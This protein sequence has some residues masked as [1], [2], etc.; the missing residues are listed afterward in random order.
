MADRRLNCRSWVF[1]IGLVL[2]LVMS[3]QTVTP[4]CA[5]EV[6]KADIRKPI[7]PDPKATAAVANATAALVKEATAGL[8]DKTGKLREKSDYFVEK[9]SADVTPDAILAALEHSLSSDRRMDAYVKWQLLSGVSGRFPEE[10]VPRAI[11][12]YRRAPEL[13][14]HPGLDRTQLTRNLNRMGMMKREKMGEINL[15]LS[16]SADQVT[17]ENQYVLHYRKELYAHLPVSGDSLLAGLDD[18]FARV[19]HGVPA[20]DMWIAVSGSIQSWSLTADSRQLNSVIQSMVQLL[21]TIRS[22]RAKPYVKMEWSED[23]KNFG[24]HWKDQMAIE[25]GKVQAMI[26]SI[27]ESAKMLGDSGYK[28]KKK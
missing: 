14:S 5:A 1:P 26:D 6:K 16:A 23:P 21:S 24:M 19:Q 4:A 3:A 28:D 10:F 8:K 20:G 25:D 2:V 27:R 17:G 18:I 11:A 13:V 7:A 9:P 15:S 12:V 22:D